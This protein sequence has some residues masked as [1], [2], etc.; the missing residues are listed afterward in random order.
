MKSH[1]G[2]NKNKKLLNLDRQVLMTI[3]QCLPHLTLPNKPISTHIK[4]GLTTGEFT[5]ISPIILPVLNQSQC[6]SRSL[7][8]KSYHDHGREF[9]TP[10]CQ[11]AMHLPLYTL[12]KFSMT[13]TSSK[14]DHWSNIRELEVNKVP[15]SS[16]WTNSFL[17]KATSSKNKKNKTETEL[18]IIY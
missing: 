18:L 15:K 6:H 13:W 3:D 1:L 8:Y 14:T 5:V 12:N 17:C 7:T 11:T 2:L 9:R 10:M 16:R 4:I